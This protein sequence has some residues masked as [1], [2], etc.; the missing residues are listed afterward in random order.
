MTSSDSTR[1]YTLIE[2]SV[3]IFLVA[4]MMGLT[5][6]KFRYTLLTDNL[7]AASRKLAGLISEVREEAIREQKTV[8]LRFDLESR[9]L[10]KTSPDMTEEEN[11]LSLENAMTLPQGVRILD[12]WYRGRGKKMMGVASVQFTKKG[13]VQETAI[14][15][16]CDDGREFTLILSPFLRRIKVADKYVDFES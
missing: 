8:I 7:K 11:A 16:G 1:G 10:W 9:M 14:H 4:L 2:L 6:P 13:Y 3:V 5:I 12:I 15:L